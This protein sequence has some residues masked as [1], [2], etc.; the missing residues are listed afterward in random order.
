MRLCFFAFLAVA[1]CGTVSDEGEDETSSAASS[2]DPC[3]I[4]RYT[5]TNSNAPGSSFFGSEVL[6]RAGQRVSATAVEVNGEDDFDVLIVGADVRAGATGSLGTVKLAEIVSKVDANYH[7]EVHDRSGRARGF[8]ATIDVLRDRP[9]CLNERRICYRATGGQCEGIAF[10]SATFLPD[11]RR[12]L[13][14]S[15][16]SQLHDTCCL[17]H[18]DGA[19]CTS[20]TRGRDLNPFTGDA[21]CAAEWNRAWYDTKWGA[22]WPQIFDPTQ[23]EYSVRPAARTNGSYR[24]LIWNV[25]QGA[26]AEGSWRPPSG[27][28][29]DKADAAEWCPS[30]TG[31]AGVWYDRCQ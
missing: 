6:A 17:A 28:W 18:S 4:A 22:S 26:P 21:V 12:Q 31:R 30:G 2:T 24:H 14:V 3:L 8:R 1:G 25:A 27:A 16:G 15:V 19:F 23:F 5:G 13:W 9:D 20:A 11:G 7:F 10:A 29:I